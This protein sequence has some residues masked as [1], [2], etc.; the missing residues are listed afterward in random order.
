MLKEIRETLKEAE[1]VAD[2][3][4]GTYTQ[5][6]V[7]AADTYVAHVKYLLDQVEQRSEAEVKICGWLNVALNNPDTCSEMKLDIVRWFT[8]TKGFDPD[9][10][11]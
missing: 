4:H 6:H 7:R 9:A 10:C 8:H 1:E 2:D 11:C 3:R 5:E